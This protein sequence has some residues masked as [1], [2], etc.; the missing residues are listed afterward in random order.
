MPSFCFALD[1][2][3]HLFSFSLVLQQQQQQQ[4]GRMIKPEEK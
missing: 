4:K 2:L 3:S 1:V